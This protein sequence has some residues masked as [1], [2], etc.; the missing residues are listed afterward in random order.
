MTTTTTLDPDDDGKPVT[1]GQFVR[2]QLAGDRKAAARD[3]ARRLT[4]RPTTT[5]TTEENE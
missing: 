5:N 4:T 3:F 1:F 2:A